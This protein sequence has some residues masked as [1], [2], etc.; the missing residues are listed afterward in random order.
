MEDAKN[1]PMAMEP[2]IARVLKAMDR[3]WFIFPCTYWNMA[4][5][6]FPPGTSGI[7]APMIKV[8]TGVFKIRA[9]IS[10]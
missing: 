10:E 3:D 9:I 2:A 8:V 7:I 4:L 5:Y 6:I 1:I